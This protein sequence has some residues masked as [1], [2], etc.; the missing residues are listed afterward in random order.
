MTRDILGLSS[1][2]A[3]SFAQY[4][5]QLV[6]NVINQSKET[7]GEPGIIDVVDESKFSNHKSHRGWDVASKKWVFGKERIILRLQ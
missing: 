2:T 4:V 3:A 6:M 1:K 5:R 7:I